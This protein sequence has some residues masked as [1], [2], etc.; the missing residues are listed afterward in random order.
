MQRVFGRGRYANVTSTLAL[1]VALGGTAYA[2]N[3]VR[4]S[5]IVNGQVKSVDIGSKQVKNADLGSNSVTSA[6]VKDG[7]LLKQDFGANQLPAGPQGPAGPAGPAGPQGPVGPSTGAASGVLSGSYPAPGFAAN[8]DKLVP[9]A[10]VYV[11]SAGAVA[12]EAHRAPVTGTPTAAKGGTGIYDIT[13]PGAAFFF[14]DDTANCIA[15]DGS[16]NIV[17]LNSIGGTNLRAFVFNAAGT[18]V[19]GS[20]YCTIYNLE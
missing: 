6:K 11:T 16:A 7:S 2:A 19:D 14:S 15:A 5:D 20:I 3:T 18:A 9:V 4:S 12:S 10:T 1:I 17:S 13:L 8:V